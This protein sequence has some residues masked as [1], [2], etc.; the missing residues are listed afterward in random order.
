MNS[1]PATSQ[2]RKES[3]PENAD[4]STNKRPRVDLTESSPTSPSS[5]T[6]AAQ[7]QSL[8]TW[9]KVP[10]PPPLSSSLTSSDPIFDKDSIFIA[11]VLPITEKEASFKHIAGLIERIEHTHHKLPDVIAGRSKRG[12][13][14]ADSSAAPVKKKGI[15][16]NHNM[17]AARVSRGVLTVSAQWPAQ[18]EIISIFLCVATAPRTEKGS[19]WYSPG[20]LRTPRN[21]QRRWRSPWVRTSPQGPPR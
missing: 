14:Q 5:S 21:G 2:K 16:P 8:A 19:H 1:S 20:R 6:P 11:Y 4:P 7:P 9:L 12:T 10:P 18:R 13:G 17:W 3:E 15:K